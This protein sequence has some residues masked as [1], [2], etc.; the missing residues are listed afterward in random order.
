MQLHGTAVQVYALRCDGQTSGV[1][2]HPER[3]GYR[4]RKSN[5]VDGPDEARL[6]QC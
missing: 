6:V 1:G 3:V 4:Q 2:L 5:D